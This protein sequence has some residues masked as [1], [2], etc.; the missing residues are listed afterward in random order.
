MVPDKWENISDRNIKV[1]SLDKILLNYE[2]PL[3]MA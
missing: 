1:K 2:V 3:K